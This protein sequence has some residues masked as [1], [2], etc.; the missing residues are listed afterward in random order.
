MELKTG[1]TTREVSVSLGLSYYTVETHRK[2]IN[3]KLDFTTK[4]EFYDFWET[5]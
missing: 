1:K 2:N 4:K 3:K 5:L